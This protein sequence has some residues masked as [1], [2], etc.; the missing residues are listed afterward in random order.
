MDFAIL[1]L[2][3]T[4]VGHLFYLELKR[5][6]C[7]EHC[8]PTSSDHNRTHCICNYKATCR[9]IDICPVIN[10]IY[11]ACKLVYQPATH[12]QTFDLQT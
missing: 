2:A 3:S 12:S 4:D 6:V 5:V 11:L 7:Q 1:K 9:N 8:H 10:Q